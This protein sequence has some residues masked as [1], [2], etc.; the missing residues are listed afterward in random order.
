MSEEIRVFICFQVLS[1][2]Q[3]LIDGRRITERQLIIHIYEGRCSSIYGLTLPT[4]TKMYLRPHKS[5]IHF[6]GTL[7]HELAHFLTFQEVAD[8]GPQWKEWCIQLMALVS[9]YLPDI[10]LQDSGCHQLCT[11]DI[12]ANCCDH[13]VT[14]TVVIN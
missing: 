1:L 8:H 13:C 4:K 11:R 5:D 10:P 12:G 3:T 7:L 14:G 2:L 9:H 6:L